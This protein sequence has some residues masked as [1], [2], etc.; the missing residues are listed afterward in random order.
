MKLNESITRI[1][2]HKIFLS[3]VLMPVSHAYFS[4]ISL[5]IGCYGLLGECNVFK[6]SASRKLLEM[7]QLDVADTILI[8]STVE[9][10]CI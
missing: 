7:N 10:I 8:L 5:G 1:F 2:N 3:M 4:V 6:N 9:G